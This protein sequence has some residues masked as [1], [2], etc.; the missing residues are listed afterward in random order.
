MDRL[1]QDVLISQHQH[2]LQTES[3]ER[4]RAAVTLDRRPL[5][6]RLGER[7]VGLGEA[8][9]ALEVPRERPHPVQDRSLVQS[10]RAAT[11]VGHVPPCAGSS[12]SLR[13]IHGSLS[14][15][16]HASCRS[17]CSGGTK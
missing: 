1:S 11:A 3:E 10:S 13:V 14:P 7:L 6:L 8:L 16:A 15:I 5:R 17:R 4:R 12:G 2:D 9:M